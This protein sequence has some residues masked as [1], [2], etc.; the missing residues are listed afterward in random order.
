MYVA[1]RDLQAARGRFALVG[2]VIALVAL[3]T[4]LLTGLAAGLVD[5]G[6]SGLRQLPM[7]QLAMEPSS[8]GTFSRSVLKEENLQPWQRVE[9]LTPPR[10][11]S[12]SRTPRTSEATP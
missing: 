6:V 12:P 7:T 5:D 4:T 1:L 9:G 10:S 2:L 3:M 8:G 11:A